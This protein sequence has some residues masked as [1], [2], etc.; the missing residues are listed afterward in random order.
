MPE[1]YPLRIMNMYAG[2]ILW[3]PV[4]L[5]LNLFQKLQIRYKYFDNSV[6][7]MVIWGVQQMCNKILSTIPAIKRA[8][9]LHSIVAC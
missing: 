7:Q 4:I 9:Y 2:S 1:N 5:C 6:N 3:E 8:N